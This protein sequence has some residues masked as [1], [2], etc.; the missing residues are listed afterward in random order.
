MAARLA[1]A[2]LLVGAAAEYLPPSL[3]PA[4]IDPSTSSLTPP[5]VDG[6]LAFMGGSV[7]PWEG[8]S[9]S[10]Y[11]PVFDTGSGKR[12]KIGSLAQM[13]K[14][15]TLDAVDAAAKAWDGGQGEWAQMSLGRRIEAIERVV[16]GLR[17]K[18][19]EIVEV[20]MW[21]IAKSAK[22]AAAE[23]DRTMEVW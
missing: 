23:F 1:C 22:D 3:P 6:N 12:I 17:A 21:E 14:K 19:E 20:L 8:E 11:S 7:T 13:D 16:K 2:I 9:S 10:V 5:F 4:G 15:A 18:R